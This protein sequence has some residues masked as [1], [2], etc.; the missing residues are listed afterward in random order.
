MILADTDVLSAFAKIGSVHLLFELFQTSVLA[1][2]EG[3][4]KEIQ[5]SAEAGHLFAK[6]LTGM[7]DEGKIQIVQLTMEER[8]EAQALPSSLGTG[9]RESIAILKNRSGILLSNESRVR[10]YCQ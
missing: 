9:E 10:H 8:T 1:V 4:F 3:V 2:T 7:V 6:A 5:R